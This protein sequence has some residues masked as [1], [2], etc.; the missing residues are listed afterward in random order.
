MAARRAYGY[1]PSVTFRGEVGTKVRTSSGKTFY[2]TGMSTPPTTTAAPSASRRGGGGAVTTTQPEQK[3][4][5][6]TGVIDEP[7][8]TVTQ[9]RISKAHPASQRQVSALQPLGLEKVQKFESKT[10]GRGTVSQAPILS[11]VEPATK[12]GIWQKPG[13]WQ[14][15]QASK[16]S[17]A[18]KEGKGFSAVGYKT[19]GFGAGILTS[20]V[21]AGYAVTHPRATLQGIKKIVTE[22]FDVGYRFREKLERDPV[23][24]AGEITGVV[25]MSKGLG[26][27]AK[28]SV[29]KPKIVA[30]KKVPIQR[31]V[32]SKSTVDIARPTAKVVVGRKKFDVSGVSVTSTP[33]KSPITTGAIV[34]DVRRGGK[35]VA[36]VKE[37]F[38][39]PKPVKVGKSQITSE[40]FEQKVFG[41]KPEYGARVTISKPVKTDVLLEKYG[42]LSATAKQ[43]KGKVKPVEVGG[44]KV[45]KVA[46][47]TKGGRTVEEWI[48]KETSVG[49][50]NLK[51]VEK[52]YRK[53]VFEKPSV[54]GKPQSVAPQIVETKSVS[55]GEAPRVSFQQIN[56]RA[57]SVVRGV[58]V[59]SRVV[60][61]K[62][63]VRTGSVI[64]RQVAIPKVRVVSASKVGGRVAVRQAGR[65]SMKH[66][67]SPVLKPVL[68]PVEKQLPRV[69]QFPVVT[70]KHITKPVVVVRPIIA[71]IP[72]YNQ[73]R[74]PV[75]K[76][77][78]SGGGVPSVSKVFVPPVTPKIPVIPVLPK[79]KIR[80][81]K[82][83]SG[84]ISRGFRYQPSLVAGVEKIFG[85]KP[86]VITGV[87]VR[88]MLR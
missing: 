40:F 86:M 79:L 73:L 21:G 59:E 56:K 29:P 25:L 31:F 27:I 7:T 75:F 38:Y 5:I 6:M 14:E 26:Q 53:P 54:R 87:D 84:K 64:A 83:G 51:A 88:P 32:T 41:K 16:A 13:A 43:V 69:R 8:K 52:F 39:S 45:G 55:V 70:P 11:R 72:I 80:K 9:I 62:P 71:Q 48:A 33:R 12:L 65:V 17:R 78:V 50:R 2:G 1:T 44:F 19:L 68:K 3:K 61:A 57:A 85:G 49:G 47:V 22:P 18:Q 58:E 15:L 42:G 23:G 20:V 35:S 76:P 82:G 34:M 37:K 77:V 4:A 46:E 60:A 81:G 36:V 74:V 28:V 67:V 66:V 63:Y 10:Y 24:I 30:V